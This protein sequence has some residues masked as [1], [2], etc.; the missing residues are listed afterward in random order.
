MS[1]PAPATR[2]LTISRQSGFLQDIQLR[3]D[4]GAAAVALNG[5][6]LWAQL[7]AND[8]SVK[9]VDL[10]VPI[11]ASASGELL[12]QMTAAVAQ[13]ILTD[14]TDISG[15]DA[16]E[17][18]DPPVLSGDD[19]AVVYGDPPLSGGRAWM[20]MLPETTAW[21]L[22]QRTPGGRLQVLLRGS[23]TLTA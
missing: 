6:T 12:V 23:A 8:R 5:T 15:G 1:T 11:I 13:G 3:C 4:G 18:G 19:A 16:A 21:D 7:W 14:T 17:T 10:A 2:N 20:G 22:L 9:Y